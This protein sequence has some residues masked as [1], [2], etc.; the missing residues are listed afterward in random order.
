MRTRAIGFI[1]IHLLTLTAGSA[2]AQE[3]DGSPSIS[4]GPAESHSLVLGLP[5]PSPTPYCNNYGSAY[6]WG[7]DALN[8]HCFGDAAGGIC[9]DGSSSWSEPNPCNSSHDP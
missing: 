8:V 6:T 3:T 4:M 7:N 2:T 5:T 1:A 9:T